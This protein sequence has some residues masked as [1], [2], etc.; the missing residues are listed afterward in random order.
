MNKPIWKMYW[1]NGCKKTVE[2]MRK[3]NNAKRMDPETIKAINSRIGEM[4]EKLDKAGLLKEETELKDW[5]WE[6]ML[7]NESKDEDRE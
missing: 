5:Q 7:E 6:I 4:A 2:R 3:K 1:N